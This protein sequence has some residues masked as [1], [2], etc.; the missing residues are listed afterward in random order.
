MRF[1]TAV[2]RLNRQVNDAKDGLWREVMFAGYMEPVARAFQNEF[3]SIHGLMR[4]RS[5]YRLKS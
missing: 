3:G 4:P 5:I 1:S 2:Y